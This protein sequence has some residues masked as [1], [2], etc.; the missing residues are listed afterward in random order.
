MEQVKATIPKNNGTSNR[1][2][3]KKLRNSSIA[4]AAL[5]GEE[6]ERDEDESVK[7]FNKS[8]SY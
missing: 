3:V 6:S 4:T 2:R 7:L 5:R 8:F 1:G